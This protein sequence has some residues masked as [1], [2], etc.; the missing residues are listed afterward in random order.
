MVE[1]AND[2]LTQS[3]WRT[4]EVA[5]PEQAQVSLDRFCERIADARARGQGT[6]A[7]LAAGERLRPVPRQPYRAQ[8]QT[9]RKVSWGAL[10]SFE[11]NRYSCHRRS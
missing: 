10:V 4:A 8:V 2:Y 1:K 5:T 7:S 6:V 9:P 11:G 3:W